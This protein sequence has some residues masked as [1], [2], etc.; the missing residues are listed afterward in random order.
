MV[1]QKSGG[2]SLLYLPLDKLI[3]STGPA[4]E[5]LPELQPSAQA[6]LQPGNTIPVETRMRDGSLGRDREA[7]P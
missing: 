5:T 4:T 1:D 6:L 2:N 7:R 3:Q